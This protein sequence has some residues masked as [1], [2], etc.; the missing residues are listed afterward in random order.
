MAFLEQM[1]FTGCIY[2]QTIDES[3][4]FKQKLSSFPQSVRFMNDGLGGQ[5]PFQLYQN[6]RMNSADDS[7]IK[8]CI[9]GQL[10]VLIWTF[11]LKPCQ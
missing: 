11:D 3:L 6:K 10:R 9:H 1:N 8:W 2:R 7:N 5:Q 4:F